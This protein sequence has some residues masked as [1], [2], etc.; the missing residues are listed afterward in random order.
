ML[1]ELSGKDKA[2]SLCLFPDQVEEHLKT[3]NDEGVFNVEL[4]YFHDD[5]EGKKYDCTI[6]VFT[7]IKASNWSYQK[8]VDF[9]E[10]K[11]WLNLICDSSLE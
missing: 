6:V 1:D 2:E 3:T 4:V 11:D 9:G 7:C 5:E 10:S 8:V